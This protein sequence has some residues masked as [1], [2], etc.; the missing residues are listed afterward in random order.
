MTTLSR[1][2]TTGKDQDVLNGIE[3]ELQAMPTLFLGGETYTPQ[4]LEAFV[5]SRIDR[6]NAVATARAAWEDAL[7]AYDTVN[8]KATIVIGDLRHLV[9]AAFGRDTPKLASF[10]FPLPRVPT[11]TSEQ[12]SNAAFKAAATR[13]ARKTM[14]K[15]QKALVKGEVPAVQPAVATTDATHPAVPPAVSTLAPDAVP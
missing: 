8:K 13:K 5:Q 1:I 9:M 3:T 4:T 15:K 14:G 2:T 11:L 6:A 7:R 12:R 10:G